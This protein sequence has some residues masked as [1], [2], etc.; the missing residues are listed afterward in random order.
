MTKYGDE[1]VKGL[2]AGSHFSSD[3]N[4]LGTGTSLRNMW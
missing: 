3:K 4:L 2:V 1:N